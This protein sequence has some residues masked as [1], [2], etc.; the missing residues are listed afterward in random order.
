MGRGYP[1]IES[2][3]AIAA[4]FSVTVDDLLSGGDVLTVAGEDRRRR[5]SRFRDPVFGLLDCSMALLLFLPFFGEK[6]G[7]GI[8]AVS[9]LGLSHV[10][11]WLKG[12]YSV[13]VLGM[14]L[15]GILTLALQNCR[16]ALWVRS[17]HG[18]SLVLSF[19]SVLLL[20]ATLQPY[21]AAL[22]FLFLIIKGFLL[23]KER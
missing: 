6:N 19:V 2:L 20:M 7:E 11:L 18:I 14:T 9:L 21:G 16:Q 17:G 3:K 4:Y 5:K 23:I 13:M 15:W 8:A 12:T 22:A 10:S 1:N